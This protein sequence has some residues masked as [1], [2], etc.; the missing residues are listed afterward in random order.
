MRRTRQFFAAILAAGGLLAA[1]TASSATAAARA[2]QTDPRIDAI[3]TGIAG[4]PVTVTGEDDPNAWAQLVASYSVD[5]P[6][7]C[8]DVVGFSGPLA[9][10]GD[11]R[12]HKVFIGPGGWITLEAIE[13]GG[14]ASVGDLHAAA[15]A[16]L[17]LIHETTHV[18]LQSTDEG[19]VEACA[20]QAFPAVI[21][22]YF[23]VS[24]TI[25]QTQTYT[26]RHAYRVKV[27]GRWVTR[28]RL[29][30]RQRTVIA[31]NLTYIAL[32]ANA[33]AIYASEPP[34]YSTGVCS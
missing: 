25:E 22:S 28:Y 24:S 8:A 33:Q 14:V 27:H 9:S 17:T 16:I 12:Y 18:K 21:A 5:C 1:L 7:S 23:G 20:V 32:V 13:N 26:M 10:P 2:L 29:V 30:R 4:F 34:P 15:D 31:P 11:P 3:A 6:S 19:R